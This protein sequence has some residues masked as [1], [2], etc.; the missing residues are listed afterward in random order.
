MAGGGPSIFKQ[1]LDLWALTASLAVVI[2][3][4]IVFELAVH[5]CENRFGNH[6]LYGP[7]LQKVMAEFT[8]LGFVAICTILAIQS[9]LVASGA[10]ESVAEFEIWILCEMLYVSVHVSNIKIA[11]D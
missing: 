4:T 1:S 3:M 10:T 5:K 6:Q 2:F 7:M 8:V 11:A 9:G